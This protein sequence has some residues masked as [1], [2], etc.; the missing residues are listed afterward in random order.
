MSFQV[1]LRGPGLNMITLVKDQALNDLLRLL[2]DNRDDRGDAPGWP[3]PGRGPRP[4]GPPMGPRRGPPAQECGPMPEHLKSRVA[5]PKSG[6]PKP[7]PEARAV[8][9]K[10]AGLPA[11]PLA[12]H[13]DLTFPEKLLLLGAW[14]E[15]RKEKFLIRAPLLVEAMVQ[16]GQSPPANPKRDVMAAI[17]SGWLTLGLYPNPNRAALTPEGW[18]RVAEMLG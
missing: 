9:A 10:L 16:A 4:F 12:D 14:L 13:A 5:Q 1:Q 15:S 18:Q 7:G 17:R 2:Q 3:E 8:M 11:A 6:A